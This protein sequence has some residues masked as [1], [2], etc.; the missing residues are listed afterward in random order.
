MKTRRYL[1]LFLF[2]FNFIINQSFAQVNDILV[3]PLGDTIVIK[4]IPDSEITRNVETAYDKIKN[5]ESRLEPGPKL[6]KFD[7]LYSNALGRLDSL[8]GVIINKQSFNSIRDVDDLLE[9]WNTY[10]SQLT[11]WSDKIN[12]RITILQLY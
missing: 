4:P 5:I 12:D 8:R 11:N 9:E 7:S 6:I 2:L 3:S 10:S 1:F